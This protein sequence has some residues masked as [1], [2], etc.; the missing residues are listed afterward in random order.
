[1]ALRPGETIRKIENLKLCLLF[2]L[3]VLFNVLT[4]IRKNYHCSK[5]NTSLVT[6]FLLV[7]GY[8][9]NIEIPLRLSPARTFRALKRYG[10]SDFTFSYAYW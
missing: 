9:V 10:G 8:S 1:M 4:L 6:I 7:R 5:L 2:S 3:N